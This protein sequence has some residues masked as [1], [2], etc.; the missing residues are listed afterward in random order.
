MNL[1]L[2]KYLLLFLTLT[3]WLQVG[4]WGFWAHQRINR[5]AVFTLPVEMLPLYKKHIEYLTEHAVDPDHRR[6]AMEG[7]AERHFLDLDR[8]GTYPFENLPRKW[9]DAVSKFSEDSLR[10]HGIVVWHI[11]LE[12][13]RLVEALKAKD[14]KR[15]LKISADLGHY[16]ADANVPLHTTSNYNGQLTN[17]KGIHGLWESR[18]PE[19]FG[20][21]FDYFVGQA[22]YI[23]KPLDQAWKI[24]FE[25]NLAVDSVL[26]MERDLT[27]SF[28]SD[29]KF[30][31]ENRN[32][33]LVKV[34]SKE[35]CEAYHT[36]LNGMVERRIRNSVIQVG[37]FWYSAWID[38][39]QPNLKEIIEQEM[40]PE[41]EK[42][43][44]KLNINDRESHDLGYFN[45][46]ENER[47][48]ETVH[49]WQNLVFILPKS[50]DHSKGQGF[51]AFAK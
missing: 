11:P 41:E 37:S 3:G 10:A 22:S 35:F 23:E 25:S 16:I 42:F 38:A 20:L 8:Y 45:P 5:L 39:G 9:K 43:E 15:I 21:N 50:Q 46:W 18:I 27:A 1:F 12:Y 2:K 34:Y 28:P 40:A 32:S 31:F 14:K 13:Y 17:Q 24:V 30:S 19:I 51:Q 4:A 47:K 29:Q 6:Y 44:K 33:V 36:L 49:S 48:N 26:K 7:E